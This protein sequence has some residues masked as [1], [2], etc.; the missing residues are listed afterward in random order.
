MRKMD[1]VQLA[2]VAALSAWLALL[3]G[4]SGHSNEPSAGD[5]TQF[6]DAGD[7]VQQIEYGLGTAPGG[8]LGAL[9]ITG[10]ITLEGVTLL[11]D[12]AMPVPLAQ[13]NTHLM[14]Q[15]VDEE[16][17]IL[18]FKVPA[19]NGGYTLSV[20]SP[21]LE[22]R[23]RVTA[24][25]A[26]DLDGD[27][28]GGDVLKQDVPIKLVKGKTVRVDLRF[29][30]AVQSDMQP[31]LW[32]TTGAVMLCDMTR[33]DGNGSFKSFYGTFFTG[34]FVIITGDSDRLLEDGDDLRQPDAD[35]NGWPDPNEAV[36]GNAA[37]EETVLSGIVTSVDTVAQTLIVRGQ[38]KL[39]T[40]VFVSPYCAIGAYSVGSGLLGQ[41]LLT[42]G[43]IG[44]AVTIRGKLG[45][46]GIMAEW[47]VYTP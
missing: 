7:V 3:A 15:L 43:L 42:T 46:G 25:V 44:K 39:T 11:D 30:R 19:A 1:L 45:P 35:H 41:T 4:C 2:L 12:H 38:D 26:E 5:Q 16:D 13:A 36:Y 24:K 37:L 29:R 22:L 18:G 23:L 47:I 32:P 33:A 6:P 40:I 34:G 9:G 28:V 8:A 14:A 10:T 21:A 31:V 20:Y 17:D 27:G